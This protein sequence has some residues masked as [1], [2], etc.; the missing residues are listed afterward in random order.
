MHRTSP[1]LA[2]C[3][4]LLQRKI[5]NDNPRSGGRCMN[6]DLRRFESSQIQTGKL[7]CFWWPEEPDTS[8]RAW[9]LV[10]ASAGGNAINGGQAV[11]RTGGAGGGPGAAHWPRPLC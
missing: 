9:I 6:G 8:R 3:V 4:H 5:E 11:R 10:S 1:L 7:S 2:H